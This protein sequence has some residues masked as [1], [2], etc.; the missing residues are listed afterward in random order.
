MAFTGTMT[1]ISKN[2]GG[3]HG[4]LF[5]S[6][7]ANRGKPGYAARRSANWELIDEPLRVNYYVNKN[8]VLETTGA[9]IFIADEKT[10]TVIDCEAAWTV[11]DASTTL[12]LKLERCQGTESVTNGDDLLAATAIDVKATANT[13]YTGTIITTS[14]INVL[15]D[16]DRLMVHFAN[17]A[18][19][20]T[21]SVALD[22]FCV[23]V[24]LLPGAVSV[25]TD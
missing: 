20:A 16:G 23:T 2:I 18:A 6:A 9:C 8:A 19:T 15:A 14:A 3:A 13:V 12:N 7:T 21:V 24:T 10:W 1:A 4:G 25:A 17:D 11:A 22:G 5:Y